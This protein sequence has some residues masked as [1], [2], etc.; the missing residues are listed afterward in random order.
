MEIMRLRNTVLISEFRYEKLTFLY[1]V[2]IKQLSYL[3]LTHGAEK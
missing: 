1:A 2:V 3:H